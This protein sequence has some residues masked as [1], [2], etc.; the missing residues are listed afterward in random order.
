VTFGNSNATVTTAAFSAAG[1]YLLRL[2][3][4]DSQL[5]NS[6]ELLI[7]VNRENHPPVAS[8]LFMTNLEDEAMDLTWHGTDADGDSMSFSVVD[9][10]SHGTLTGTPPD[11]RY[12]PLADF[13]G[14]D[15]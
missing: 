4:T 8:N 10:P 13:N 14:I 7:T 1:T 5:T 6:D 15:S 12:T 3:A 9:A 2:T 11:V